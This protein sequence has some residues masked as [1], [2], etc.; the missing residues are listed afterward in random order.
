MKTTPDGIKYGIELCDSCATLL[1]FDNGDEP[2]RIEGFESVHEVLEYIHE[3]TE[4]LASW[5]KRL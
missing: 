2:T 5:A 4:G 1:L 3:D